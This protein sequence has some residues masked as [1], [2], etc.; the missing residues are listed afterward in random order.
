MKK[1]C[2]FL[3]LLEMLGFS[4]WF[5]NLLASFFFKLFNYLMKKEEKI[6]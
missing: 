6:N 3:I 1:I 4:P 2:G 5:E